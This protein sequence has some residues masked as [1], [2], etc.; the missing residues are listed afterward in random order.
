MA[1][2]ATFLQCLV[3]GLVIIANS[4]VDIISGTAIYIVYS[5]Q[6][7]ADARATATAL[8]NCKDD[9]YG[10]FAC[11]DVRF[12]FFCSSKQDNLAFMHAS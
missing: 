9:C 6:V 8:T 1:V 4:Q 3:L 10:D 11:M 5:N 12:H 7:K 2:L